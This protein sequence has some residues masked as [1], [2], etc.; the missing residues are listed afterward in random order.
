[1]SNSTPNAESLRKI[2]AKTEA[3]SQQKSL[4]HYKGARKPAGKSLTA[5]KGKKK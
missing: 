5:D 2:A 1:M 4:L 3:E